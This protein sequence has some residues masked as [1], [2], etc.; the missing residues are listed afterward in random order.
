MTPATEIPL[1]YVAKVNLNTL[2]E[3]TPEDFTFRY[4][5]ISCVTQ[6]AVAIP[7]ET[8]TFGTAPSR[9]RRQALAGDTLVSTV[10]TYLRAI[11]G[12]SDSEDDLVFSTGFAVVHPDGAAIHPPF[13]TYQLQAD[14]FIT[15]VEAISTGVSY[16][17]T[18]ASE[19]MR[20]PVWVPTFDRQ[21]AISAFLD[22]ETAEID[23]VIAKQEELIRLLGERRSAVI[24]HAVT[25]GLNP[26]APMKDSGVEWLGE[27]PAHWQVLA[28]KRL[29]PV[30]RGAS[31]RPI[32]DPVYFDDDGEWAWVRIADVTASGGEL[33]QTTQRLSE[34]GSSLSVKMAPG[35]LFVSIAGTVGKPCITKIKACIHDGFVYFP[36]LPF[37][38]EFL[39]RI[40]E[41]GECYRGLGKLGTQLNLNTDTVGGI[42]I[43][44]PPNGEIDEIAKY[45]RAA[46]EALDSV[47]A[48]A[49]ESISL[50]RERRAALISDAVTGRLN[51]ETYGKSEGAA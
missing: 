50:M 32:D 14:R 46:L 6:G 41:A 25:K 16:P 11:A 48:K 49:A 20:L 18:T 31:P 42:K 12:V 51:V 3:D 4:V 8:I 43:A 36:L 22:R 37:N 9:A 28:I 1:K 35:D 5:D 10:R 34:L 30:Q 47:A 26:D 24:S 39:F 23:A 44:L 13:L 21:R 27:V 38:P 15:S 33:T 2:G 29:T 40:F 17:A 45:L 19:V 7:D